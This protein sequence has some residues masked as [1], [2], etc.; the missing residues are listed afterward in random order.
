MRKVLKGIIYQKEVFMEL[1]SSAKSMFSKSGPQWQNKQ[2]IDLNT[3]IHIV[4]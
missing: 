3:D 2:L 4:A 1:C